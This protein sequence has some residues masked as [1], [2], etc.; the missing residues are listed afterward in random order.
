[1]KNFTL[2]INLLSACLSYSKVPTRFME[3]LFRNAIKVNGYWISS[4]FM[5]R[6]F[7]ISEY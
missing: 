4:Y 5:N 2:I 3:K 6:H 1:M 7:E